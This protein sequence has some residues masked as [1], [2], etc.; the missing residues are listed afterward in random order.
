MSLRGNLG[1]GLVLFFLEDYIIV[2]AAPEVKPSPLVANYHSW[3]LSLSIYYIISVF[4]LFDDYAKDCM[5]N[6]A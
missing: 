5:K 6:R 3:K 4:G 2:S 1:K